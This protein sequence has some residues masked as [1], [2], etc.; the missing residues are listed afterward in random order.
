MKNQY[1]G[2]VNDYRKYGL[3]RTLKRET[4]L[5]LGVCW[6][7]TKD[8]ERP[9][10]GKVSY[11]DSPVRYRDF[12]PPLFDHLVDSVSTRGRRNVAEI[13]RAELLPGAW[14]HQELLMDDAAEREAYFERL[15]ARSTHTDLLFFDPDNGIEVKSTSYGRKNSSKFL[16]WREVEAAYSNGASVLFYQHFRREPRD[17]MVRRLANEC[18]RLTGAASVSAFRTSHVVFLLLAQ[19]RHA[20]ALRHAGNAVAAAWDPELNFEVIDVSQAGRTDARK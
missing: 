14:F 3:L 1:Y 8:D 6:M 18:A 2:D 7:L 5:R 4:D 16:Y 11:L 20:Q 17:A 19:D 10:G 9:D 13:E 15:H 12:D